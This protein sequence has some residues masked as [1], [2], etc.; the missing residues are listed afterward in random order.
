MFCNSLHTYQ[1]LNVNYQ[2]L[3]KEFQSY[4]SRLLLVVPINDKFL[5]DSLFRLLIEKCYRI[6]YGFHNNQ[7]QEHSLRK[8]PRNKMSSRIDGKVI[9][10]NQLDTMY[11]EY[12]ELIHHSTPTSTDLLNFRQLGSIDSQ[13][14]EYIYI[15]VKIL[16]TIFIED[17]YIPNLRLTQLDLA[18]KSMLQKQVTPQTSQIFKNIGLI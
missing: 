11:G 1:G 8:H 10:K 7:L 15:R 3:L 12:S 18:T 2:K 6:L 16:K 13:L 5:V 9:N 17:F 4:I 14:I